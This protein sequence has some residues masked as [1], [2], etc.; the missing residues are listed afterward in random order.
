MISHV[1]PALA[2]NGLVKCAACAWPRRCGGA[3]VYAAGLA[4]KSLCIA[5]AVPTGGWGT[6]ACAIISSIA[7]GYIGG[8]IGESTGNLAGTELYKWSES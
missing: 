7:G 6:L 5:V 8:K 2:G 1:G 3:G 4:T